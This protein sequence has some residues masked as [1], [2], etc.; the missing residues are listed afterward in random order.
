MHAQQRV[1][2]PDARL[3]RVLLLGPAL[4]R[5]HARDELV[6]LLVHAELRRPIVEG[7]VGELHLGELVG[8]GLQEG[9]V[10][11]AFREGLGDVTARL[12]LDKGGVVLAELLRV[13]EL[14]LRDESRRADAVRDGEPG[15]LPGRLL[16][17][18]HLGRR[19][20]LAVELVQHPRHCGLVVTVLGEGAEA[21]V[22]RGQLE[23]VGL[24]LVVGEG[25]ADVP[26]QVDLDLA[27]RVVLLQVVAPRRQ[28]PDDA[29]PLVHI[30]GVRDR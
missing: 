8:E 29:L 26:A 25:V 3:R 10:L 19:R 28:L 5:R 18:L 14:R 24:A 27:R 11:G 4:Q 22:D 30:L 21:G 16:V 12:A 9:D 17:A 20:K 2:V 15:E 7:L 13:D 23:P 6:L 1:D